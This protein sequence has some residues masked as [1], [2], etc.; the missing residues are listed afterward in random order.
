VKVDPISSERE[1][2]QAVSDYT[3]KVWQWNGC[4][5]DDYAG[6]PTP[7]ELI[8]LLESRIAWVKAHKAAV[9]GYLNRRSGPHWVRVIDGSNSGTED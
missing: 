5:D 8:A 9:D 1:L 4:L 6:E 2:Y 7:E 3:N